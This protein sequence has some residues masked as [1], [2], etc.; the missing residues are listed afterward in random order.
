MSSPQLFMF[1]TSINV[2]VVVT[3]SGFVK[4]YIVKDTQARIEEKFNV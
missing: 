2:N 3:N 4:E 1:G